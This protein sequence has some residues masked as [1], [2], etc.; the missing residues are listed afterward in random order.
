MQVPSPPEVQAAEEALEVS[1]GRCGKCAWACQNP[2]PGMYQIQIVAH[3]KRH[4]ELEAM[5]D[6]DLRHAYLMSEIIWDP[7]DNAI[8]WAELRKRGVDTVRMQ[9]PRWVC[10]T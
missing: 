7:F 5:S 4:A 1:G 3:A 6:E 2:H 9:R 10:S 8:G